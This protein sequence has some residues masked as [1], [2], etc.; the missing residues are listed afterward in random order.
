MSNSRREKYQSL[1]RSRKV[2]TWNPF[3]ILRSRF[4]HKRYIRDRPII[5]ISLLN[6]KKLAKNIS[7][8]RGSA[9]VEF[10]VLTLPLFV[11]FA[12][13]LGIVNSQSQVAFDVHNLARQ[14]GRAFIT[15][16]SEALAAPRVKTVVDAFST[17]ILSAHGITGSP[18]VS[19]LCSAA[20]CLTPG[21]HVQV[22]ISLDD[23]SMKPTGYLRFWSSSPSHI[24][25]RDTQVV[26]AWRSTA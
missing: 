12:L 14:V 8:E 23:N 24:V 11:P 13:Y 21:A 3:T 20:P 17:K 4:H 10:V 19:I 7:D 15:S 18:Q 16:P 22:T 9:V 2:L 25:A 6:Y 1:G 26:D 5:K